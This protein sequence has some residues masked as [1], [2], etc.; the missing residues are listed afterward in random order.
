MQTDAVFCSDVMLP[1]PEHF[2]GTSGI[3]HPDDLQTVKEDLLFGKRINELKFRM[4]TTYGE[5]KEIS[6]IRLE[7]QDVETEEFPCGKG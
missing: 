3:V 2:V 7:K 6:G 1:P 5:V 4:I